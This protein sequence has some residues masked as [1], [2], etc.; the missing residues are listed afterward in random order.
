MASQYRLRTPPNLLPN[1]NVPLQQQQQQQQQQSQEPQSPIEKVRNALGSQS[2]V[3]IR[4][5]LF[6]ILQGAWPLEAVNQVTIDTLIALPRLLCQWLQDSTPLGMEEQKAIYDILQPEGP[7]VNT[8]IQYHTRLS[9]RSQG[10]HNV[11]YPKSYDLSPHSVDASKSNSSLLDT[12]PP[13]ICLDAD[14]LP[15]ELQAALKLDPAKSGLPLS[16]ASR[17]SQEKSQ[18]ASSPGM[19]EFYLDKLEYFLFH[20]ARA[21]VPN[22][23]TE[24]ASKQLL[25]SSSTNYTSNTNAW[26]LAALT[27]EYIGFFVPVSV[28][29]QRSELSG[30]TSGSSSAPSSPTSPSLSPANPEYW[31]QRINELSPSRPREY[32]Q[33]VSFHPGSISID[34]LDMTDYDVSFELACFFTDTIAMLWLPQIPY[35]TTIALQ[36]QGIPITSPYQ[37]GQGA[38]SQRP[39]HN[40]SRSYNRLGASS[41]RNNSPYDASSLGSG[42]YDSPSKQNKNVLQTDSWNWNPTASQHRA[43][44][45]II[46]AFDLMALGESQMED[47]YSGAGGRAFQDDSKDSYAI[48][49]NMNSTIRDSLRS[50]C[51]NTP[52]CNIISYI[53][54]SCSNQA[55]W[56]SPWVTQPNGPPSN[57]P[58]WVSSIGIILEIWLRYAFP[59]SHPIYLSRSTERNQDLDDEAVPPIWESRIALITKLVN[60]FLYSP[61]IS[62][63]MTRVLCCLDIGTKSA[64]GWSI[65]DPGINDIHSPGV[66]TIL[67]HP[68]SPRARAAAAA[69]RMREKVEDVFHLTHQKINFRDGLAIIERFVSVF[70]DPYLRSTLS[71]IEKLH[72]QRYPD[73][74]D[75][76][77]GPLD[78]RRSGTPDFLHRSNSGR[79]ASPFNETP[80]I[81]RTMSSSSSLSNKA[82]SGSLERDMERPGTPKSSLPSVAANPKLLQALNSILIKNKD[83]IFGAHQPPQLLNAALLST[84]ASSLI[85]PV[86]NQPK[87]VGDAFVSHLSQA[88]YIINHRIKLLKDSERSSSTMGEIGEWLSRIFSTTTSAAFSSKYDG[89]IAGNNANASGLSSRESLTIRI[90]NLQ[91]V[92]KR[93]DRI[94]EK[95]ASLFE[96]SGKYNREYINKSQQ[97]HHSG[98]S[99][100][101]STPLSS[102]ASRFQNERRA[103][104]KNGSPYRSDGILPEMSMGSLTPR[105]RYELKAGLRKFTSESL[106]AT[107]TGSPSSC[108]IDSTDSSG[109][110][111]SFTSLRY[112][113]V[114][115]KSIRFR[116]LTQDPALVPQGPRADRMPRSYENEWILEKTLVWNEVLNDF[117]QHQILDSIESKFIGTG[118]IPPRVRN[119]KI[120]LRW[121]AAYPNMRFF[122]M[123]IF[124]FFVLRWSL[125]LMFS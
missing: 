58:E 90:H 106:M 26:L 109:E 86:F 59:W 52:L 13:S 108:R 113:G 56:R 57:E 84:F 21:L 70:R 38:Y 2:A 111:P 33:N 80:T 103:S 62:L 51:W 89:D 28:P 78:S 124:L 71:E 16:Y 30:R 121:I 27:R 76:E 48:R 122:T 22:P 72:Y 65:V 118:T 45:R 82:T 91:G 5:T 47:Y 64:R 39:S 115:S 101:N 61:M 87:T 66:T 10:T 119:F 1:V 36:S 88:S 29:E 18:N 35:K 95:C 120:N 42:P 75:R 125:G 114:E 60:P 23:L 50:K 98:I 63:F 37:H 3:I 92:K 73:I 32:S 112:R 8:L 19:I 85:I 105:G 44:Q 100:Q 14:L 77:F 96:L 123:L 79:S 41:S 67:S 34:M 104:H 53:S 25:V 99:S 4:N 49:L 46:V 9:Q 11:I 24:I 17:F 43:F 40:H 31:K 12:S 20:F 15:S 68:Y 116:D 107:P 7:W 55:G 69:G 94:S 6:P 110:S 74:Y 117:Y 54:V 97:P 81:S 93:L 83:S 102:L